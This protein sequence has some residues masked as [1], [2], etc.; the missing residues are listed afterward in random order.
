MNKMLKLMAT[1]AITALLIPALHAQT[2]HPTPSPTQT[3]YSGA[4]IWGDEN[5]TTSGMSW[6]GTLEVNSLGGLGTTTLTIDTASGNSMH[7]PSLTLS[8]LYFVGTGNFNLSVDSRAY[9]NPALS[10][11]QMSSGTVTLDIPNLLWMSTVDKWGTGTLVIPA[12][13]L[14]DYAT[15]SALTVHE[16]LL[17]VNAILA[18]GPLL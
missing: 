4:Y 11:Y 6:A 14:S 7:G 1:L 15:S 16:G 5:W 9:G 10:V 3:V 2:P 17:V 13:A 12:S 8:E 18:D